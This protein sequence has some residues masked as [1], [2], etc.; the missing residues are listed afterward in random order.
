MGFSTPENRTEFIWL[1]CRMR[2]IF[3]CLVGTP[4][5]D[6]NKALLFRLKFPGS[7]KEPNFKFDMHINDL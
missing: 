4:R 3:W 5:R 1:L 2:K 7:L 6:I